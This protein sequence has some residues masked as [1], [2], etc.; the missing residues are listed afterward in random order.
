MLSVIHKH[1]YNPKKE[2]PHTH[3]LRPD[4]VQTN[5][6]NILPLGSR[7][8]SSKKSLCP[9]RGLSNTDRSRGHCSIIL[10][11]DRLKDPTYYSDQ[12]HHNR[13]I[14]K[15]ASLEGK[16]LLDL[17]TENVTLNKQIVDSNAKD[18]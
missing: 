14:G 1:K 9:Q 5:A 18:F 8:Y 4:D 7:F 15:N 12:Q 2:P 3:P 10:S 13:S 17:L 11:T 6:L 16:M